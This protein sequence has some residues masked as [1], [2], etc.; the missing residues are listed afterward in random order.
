MGQG[1]AAAYGG[2][3]AG[4]SVWAW[5][6]IG[7]ALLVVITVVVLV[8]RSRPR[9]FWLRTDAEVDRLARTL[10]RNEDERIA[11]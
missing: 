6:W 10:D 2:V 8:V 4:F 3:F 1:E 5:M 7:V 11:S 9:S